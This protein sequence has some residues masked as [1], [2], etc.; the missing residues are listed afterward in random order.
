MFADCLP[1]KFWQSGQ[2]CIQHVQMN[3]FPPFLLKYQIV[4]RK[5]LWE[6]EISGRI[7]RRA[8]YVSRVTFWEEQFF[9]KEKKIFLCSFP[10]FCWN[11]SKFLIHFGHLG[12]RLRNCWWNCT[13]LVRTKVLV[14][15]GVCR[16]FHVYKTISSWSEKFWDLVKKSFPYGWQFGILIF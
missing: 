14:G 6:P 9:W 2:N 10:T 11:F 5:G 7:V 3:V 16:S 4:T 12:Q 8:F 13:P 1:D 15:K